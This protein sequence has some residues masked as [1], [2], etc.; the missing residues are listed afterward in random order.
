[1]PITWQAPQHGYRQAEGPQRHSHQTRRAAQRRKHARHHLS[2]SQHFAT[3]EV[4][5]PVCRTRRLQSRHTSRRHIL[6]MDGLAQAL[7]CRLELG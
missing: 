2:V 1:M 5:S 6:G 3:R 7:C 4:V